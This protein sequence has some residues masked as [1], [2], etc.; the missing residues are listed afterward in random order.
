MNNDRRI[1]IQHL[2]GSRNGYGE[3]VQEWKQFCKMWASVNHKGGREGFYARQVV[4]EGVVVFKM[5]YRDDIRETMRIVHNERIY[6]I[7]AIAEVGR[8][9]WL[10]IT[11]KMH[12]N[13]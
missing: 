7:N 2:V 5:R 13:E 6:N 12:D 3:N 10:E 4:A 11:A 8:K 1:E 9:D